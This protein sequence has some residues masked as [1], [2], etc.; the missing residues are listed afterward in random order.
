MGKKKSIKTT[1]T[2]TMKITY[3]FLALTMGVTVI[4]SSCSNS[5][6]K[7]QNE[8][9]SQENKMTAKIEVFNDIGLTRQTLSQNGIG[10]LGTWKSDGMG[11]YFS[12]TSYHEFGTNTTGMK[13]NLAYYLESESEDFVDRVKLVL[14]INNK[15]EKKQAIAKFKSL[16]DETFQ[17]LSIDTPK[18][19]TISIN[20]ENE[21]QF[22]NDKYSTTLKLE[23]SNIDSW[24]LIINSKK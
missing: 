13:N 14:N 4:L 1:K 9:S 3:L 2:L 11:G 21:F 16:M 12:I 5:G 19:L 6:T 8:L 22:E 7:N 10:E 18:E 20:N 23:K 17:D 24:K 15:N